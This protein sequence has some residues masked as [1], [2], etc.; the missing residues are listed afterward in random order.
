MREMD[1]LF[2]FLTAFPRS[3]RA[4]P[5]RLVG[6]LGAKV[7]GDPL[8]APR[9]LVVV[10]LRPGLERSGLVSGIV[11]RIVESADRAT[12]RKGLVAA[13]VAVGRH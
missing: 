6:L 12:N 11:P 13:G 9:L 3:R 10:R 4:W 8:G 2:A 1:G 5:C 7:A